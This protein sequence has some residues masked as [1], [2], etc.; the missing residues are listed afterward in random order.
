MVEEAKGWL[1]GVEGEKKKK[2]EAEEGLAAL[3]DDG[4][5]RNSVEDYFAAAKEIC[6]SDGGPPR[7]FCPVEC[8][9][10]LKDSPTLLF[11]PG[12]L[13]FVACISQFM[14]EH[15]LKVFAL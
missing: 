12:F 8:G 2:G 15:L 7:W 3:W 9:P 6:R 5:G 1:L 13:K 14:I 10:P 4:Y 11:L